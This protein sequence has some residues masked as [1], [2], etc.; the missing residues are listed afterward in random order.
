MGGTRASRISQQQSFQQRLEARSK[1]IPD[2]PDYERRQ[3]KQNVKL[4]SDPGYVQD[5]A[6][7]QNDFRAAMVDIAQLFLGA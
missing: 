1:Q 3:A 2:F 6:R 4:S 5:T 7:L